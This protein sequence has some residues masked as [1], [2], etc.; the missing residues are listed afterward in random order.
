MRRSS[1]VLMARGKPL[2]RKERANNV[3]KRDILNRHGDKARAVLDALLDKYADQG[4]LNLDDSNILQ[5]NPFTHMG[6][7]I[8]LMRAFGKKA[9]YQ[10][11]IHDL[12]QALYAESA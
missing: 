8:E 9:D 6:T 5:I 4:V 12:Q 11:A 10:Q 2:T 1:N 3:R 7:P